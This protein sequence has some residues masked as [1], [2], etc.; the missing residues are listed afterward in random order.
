M[1]LFYQHPGGAV[2]ANVEVGV[3]DY[4]NPQHPCKI[5][6]KFSSELIWS[7]FLAD[8]NPHS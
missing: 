7:R 3:L 4:S 5:S 2:Y 8:A 6:N 1:L